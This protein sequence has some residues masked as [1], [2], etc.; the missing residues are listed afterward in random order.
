MNRIYRDFIY[1]INFI[2]YMVNE[3]RYKLYVIVR[4]GMKEEK[5]RALQ[6]LPNEGTKIACALSFAVFIFTILMAMQ[7]E[8]T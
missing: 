3:R 6:L 1:S 8:N 2:S 5:E 4:L 7:R